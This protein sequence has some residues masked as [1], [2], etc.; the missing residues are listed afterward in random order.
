MAV[1]AKQAGGF[2]LPQLAIQT[3]S[4]TLVG[5]SPLIVHAWSAKAIKQMDDKHQKRA[6]AGREA[7]VPWNDFCESLYWLSEKPEQP[8]EADVEAARFGFPSVAF[9]SA[10]VTACTS[11]GDITKVAARQAFH[12]EGEMAEIKAGPPSMR[13]DVTRVGMGKPD[14]RYRGEFMPW[15]VDLLVKFNAN[16]LSAEQVVNLFETAGFAVGVGEWRPERDGPYGR[17]HVRRE[18]EAV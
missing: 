5:D 3:M 6:T 12:V 16:L 1:A 14:L 10:A 17:F 13:Q 7:K 9:K 15:N 8:T 11:I 4:I 18:G 2:Q